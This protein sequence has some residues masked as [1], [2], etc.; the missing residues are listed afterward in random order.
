MLLLVYITEAFISL[1]HEHSPHSLSTVTV[2]KHQAPAVSLTELWDHIIASLEE[3]DR[4]SIALCC[5]F[6]PH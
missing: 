3:A 5:R 1:E 6:A 4:L 2:I